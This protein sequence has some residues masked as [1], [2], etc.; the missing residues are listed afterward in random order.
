[1]PKKK[2]GEGLGAEKGQ[3]KLRGKILLVTGARN[4]RYLDLPPIG[5]SGEP[6]P[7]PVVPI[8]RPFAA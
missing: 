1:M 7:D 5:F 6:S 4:P 2:R 8:G 3:I